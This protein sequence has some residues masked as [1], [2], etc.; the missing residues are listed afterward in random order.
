[1]SLPVGFRTASGHC[2]RSFGRVS[3]RPTWRPESVQPSRFSSPR[4]ADVAE[5]EYDVNFF[6]IMFLDGV[7]VIPPDAIRCRAPVNV[8]CQEMSSSMRISLPLDSHIYPNTPKFPTDK[9]G[10]RTSES[11]R[12][13][14]RQSATL[15]LHGEIL[16]IDS[17]LTDTKWPDV[18]KE[19]QTGWTIL[20][21][22][23]TSRTLE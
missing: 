10:P 1:M 14:A 18:H 21:D 13:S 5:L 20:A 6:N 11:A 8:H 12:Q 2:L 17:I 3:G 15:F 22:L 7:G 16:E 23:D 19:T 9:P 4:F